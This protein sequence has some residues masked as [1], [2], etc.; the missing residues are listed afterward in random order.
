MQTSHQLPNEKSSFLHYSED[1]I[2]FN[3]AVSP[4]IKEFSISKLVAN[5]IVSQFLGNLVTTDSWSDAWIFKG[6]SK[7]LEYQIN[8]ANELFVSEVLH[9]TLQQQLFI[10]FPYS[11]DAALGNEAAEKGE[12]L[13][14]L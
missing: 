12:K 2:L 7:F 5:G 1:L 8:D 14:F 11:V 4:A 13:L 6:I 9:P 10:A 3:S